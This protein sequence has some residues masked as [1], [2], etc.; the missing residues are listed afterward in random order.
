MRFDTV[1]AAHGIEYRRTKPNHPW[2]DAQ[3]ERVNRTIKD[4]TVKWLHNDKHDQ[5]RTHL[6]DFVAASDFARCL[7]PLGGP[8]PSDYICKVR[9]SSPDRFISDPIHQM[10]RLNT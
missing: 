5:L 2:T 1:C 8:A 4:A 9:T 7:K 6:A 3:V 10:S